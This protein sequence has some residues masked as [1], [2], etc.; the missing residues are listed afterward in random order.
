MSNT[1]KNK[2]DSD[3]KLNKLLD[4]NEL[5]SKDDK[6]LASL[7]KRIKSSSHP[8]TVKKTKET[9]KNQEDLDLTPRVT[10]HHRFDNEKIEEEQIPEF[11]VEDEGTSAEISFEDQDLI[12][13]EKVEV[14]G[15]QFLEVKPIGITKETYDKE[16]VEFEDLTEWQPVKV[17]KKTEEKKIEPKE[18]EFEQIKKPIEGK[19]CKKC[20]VKLQGDYAFCLNCGEKV[21]GVEPVKAVEEKETPSFTPVKQEPVGEESKIIEKEDS[22]EESV[23]EATP[24]VFQ[25]IPDE[26]VEEKKEEKP[27]SEIKEESKEDIVEIEP[28]I[29][30]ET[31]V[32]EIK[33]EQ[34][35]EKEIISDAEKIKALE[36]LKNI[37]PKLAI[38]LYDR[39]YTS[40][41]SIKELT[42]KDLKKIKGINR[43]QAKEIKE[44][45]DKKIIESAEP[46][47]IDMGES[48]EGEISKDQVE[49]EKIEEE[50]KELTPHPV[51]L[52]RKSAEW[53]PVEEELEVEEPKVDRKTKVQAFED[54][55]CIDD[56]TAVLLYDSGILSIED[57]SILSVQ[58]ITKIKGIKRKQAKEIK[59]EIDKKTEWTSFEEQSTDVTLV[60]EKIKNNLDEKPKGVEEEKEF[61]VEQEAIDKES[62]A[63]EKKIKSHKKEVQEEEFFIQEKAEDV[64][65]L[66]V[67]EDPIFKEIISIDLKTARLLKNKNIN[68]IEELH[69]K[70]IKDLVKIRGIKRKHAKEIKKEVRK[71][72]QDKKLE[73]EF[74][75]GENPFIKDDAEDAEW[76][77]YEGTAP[78]EH[79]KESTGYREGDYTL[80]EKEIKSQS[81]KKRT[82]RFFSKGEPEDAYPIDLPEG[83]VVKINKK[84]GVPYL[85][86]K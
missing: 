18:V 59:E 32:G 58:D 15:P 22:L 39:G 49:D 56:K 63:L 16:F 40:F 47:S 68:S 21:E 55:K 72:I 25:E 44:E 4:K 78:E 71:Y 28:I 61:I 64:P 62:K 73:K 17:D 57:L 13:V 37:D 82:V 84:T 51:E 24:V 35:P 86:K 2:K 66:K 77:S 20:G 54:V 8:K 19:F 48:A 81:D 74:E 45:I 60:E 1:R 23:S 83:Y 76:V 26:K 7:K 11:K 14:K 41:D 36:D 30:K 80:F 70:T 29:S 85:K 50:S 53:K 43:K 46:K 34:I 52:S 33:E 3:E 69:K 10:I 5:D 6:Y 42:I 38:L 67:E 27:K 79:I 12:D 65:T 31:A 75:R 9:K